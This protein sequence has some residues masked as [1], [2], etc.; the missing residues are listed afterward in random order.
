MLSRIITAVPVR[1]GQDFIRQTLESIARQTVR[2]DRV[3]VFDNRST[4]RT[5]E[6]VRDF[7]DLACEISIAE[8]EGDCMFANFN[9]AL[10][11]AGQTDYLHILHADDLIEPAFY[12]TMTGLL[13]DCPGFALGWCEDE[14]IDENNQHL[15]FSG[16]GDGKA[17]VLAKDIFLQRKAEIGNQA[18]CASLMKTSG[19]PAPCL[20]P[21]DYPVLGDQIFWAAFGAHC[22]KL[23]HLHR[24]LAKYRWHGANGTTFLGPSIQILV[25]DE[26]RTMQTNEALRGQG[27]AWHRELKLK[28]L[29]AVRSGI[30]AKR[31]RQNG[32]PTYSQ[33]IVSASRQVTGWPLWLAGQ[34]LVEL[35]DLYL[36]GLLRRKRHPKNVYN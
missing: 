28:G 14:R 25:L 27:M 31:V 32:N 34:T 19:Q 4:D 24:P 20:F 6:I 15:S 16:K 7:K 11:L 1:N 12:E 21:L 29:F 13:N 9:R 26:W 22:Q 3:V 33:Q 2:P 30:K 10:R 35:R 8:R 17:E 36:F 5:L 23:V 18:F